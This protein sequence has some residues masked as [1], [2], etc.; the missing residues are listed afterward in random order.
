MFLRFANHCILFLFSFHIAPQLLGI[1]VVTL[2]ASEKA[3]FFLGQCSKSCSVAILM[4]QLLKTKTK[5][6][7]DLIAH[8]EEKETWCS[9]TSSGRR[10]EMHPNDTGLALE[11]ENKTKR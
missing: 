2:K 11:S 6:S 4:S 9:L 10:E 5:R 7:A 8:S 3:R 1:G